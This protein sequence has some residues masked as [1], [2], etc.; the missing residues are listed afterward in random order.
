MSKSRCFVALV[1]LGSIVFLPIASR[2][3]AIHSDPA[4]ICD[5]VAGNLVINCGFETLPPFSNW[6]VTDAA[7]GTDIGVIFT[8]AHSGSAAA[9]FGAWAEL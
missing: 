8:A 7:S 4:S 1:F 5:A 3:D 6:T 9:S 2:A